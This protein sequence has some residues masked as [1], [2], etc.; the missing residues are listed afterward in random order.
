MQ[1]GRLKRRITIEQ[2]TESRSTRGGVAVAW[3]AFLDAW[4]DI[5]TATAREIEAGRARFGE[6]THRIVMRY[7]PGITDKMRVAYTRAPDA[8]RYFDIRGVIDPDGDR[9]ELHLMV[10]EHQA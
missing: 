4:V 2:P 5:Q 3:T 6:L 1:A 9:R 10:W 8:T 7:R